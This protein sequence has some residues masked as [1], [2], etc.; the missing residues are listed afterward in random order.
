MCFSMQ[1]SKEYLY[2]LTT[3]EHLVICSSSWI[4]VS[5]ILSISR[6]QCINLVSLGEG[7]RGSN[8]FLFSRALSSPSFIS[9]GTEQ[10]RG[11]Q[12]PSNHNSKLLGSYEHLQVRRRR[13]CGREL[14]LRGGMLCP[15]PSDE[16]QRSAQASHHD[17]LLTPASL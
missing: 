2:Y 13:S 8:I 11:Q 12:I 14:V 10:R 5:R 3:T 4:L 15:S 1:F 6:R 7:H 9:R 17:P 16:G